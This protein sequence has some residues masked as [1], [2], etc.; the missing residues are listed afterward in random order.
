MNSERESARAG[1]KPTYINLALCTKKKKE[2]LLDIPTHTVSVHTSRS[3]RK[4]VKMSK[5]R[6][7]Y[8]LYT[9]LCAYNTGCAMEIVNSRMCIHTHD[10]SLHRPFPILLVRIERIFTTISNRSRYSAPVITRAYR[11]YFRGG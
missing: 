2:L 5:Y 3:G 11:K 7:R 8:S 1:E 9:V 6:A 4:R 10:I